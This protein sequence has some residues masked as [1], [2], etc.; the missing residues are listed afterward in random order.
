MD[1]PIQLRRGPTP[2]YKMLQNP[3]KRLSKPTRKA[4]QKL[5]DGKYQPRYQREQN[6]E[7]M[8]DICGFWQERF[9]RKRRVLR[10]R[11][12]TPVS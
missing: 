9:Y 6:I 7:I 8:Q 2:K 11:V 10:S 4:S 5:P 1:I 12:L 3:K